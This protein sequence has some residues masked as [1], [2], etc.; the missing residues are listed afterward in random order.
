MKIGTMMSSAA[1]TAALSVPT[2][3][4]AVVPLAG[5]ALGISGRLHLSLDYSDTDISGEDQNLS[6]SSNESYLG[7]AGKYQVDPIWSLLW[8][9][10]QEISIDQGSGNFATR[11][12]YAG[13]ARDGF[14]TLEFGTNDTP[15]KTMGKRWAV[16]TDTVADR[17]ALLG[18]GALATNVM[19]QRA[20]NSILY[21]NNIQGLDFQIMYSTDGQDSRPGEVDDNEKDVFSAAAWYP[22]GS[23]ELSAAFESWSSLDTDVG[24]GTATGLRLAATQK[25]SEQAK[26]GVIFETIDTANDDMANLDRDVIGVNASFREGANTFDVQLLMAGNYRG[27]SDSGAFN[28]GLGLTHDI[29][30]HL[31]IYG[32]LSL[33]DNES[34][35]LYKGVDGGHGDEVPTE[36]GGTPYSLSVGG[37]F[38]F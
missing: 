22:L 36:L 32:A 26:V 28:L 15:Y 2:D 19:N 1:L 8:Q 24:S 13:I 17:R 6:V 38:R 3:A 18:A 21:L 12:S 10:E 25:I 29:D 33:T 34:N 31:Q 27:V 4:F 14:G 11:N 30:P 7:L 37:I 5:D 20:K 16:L 23:L 9:I 35:A